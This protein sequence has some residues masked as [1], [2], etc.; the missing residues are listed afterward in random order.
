MRNL[1]ISFSCLILI[2]LYIPSEL[3]GKKDFLSIP[4]SK[5]TQECIDCHEVENPGLVAD[6]FASRHSKTTPK[7]A[8]Q[9]TSLEK[10]VSS[11]NIPE[12]LSSNAVGCYECHSL[13]SF[14]HKDNFEHYGFKINVIVSPKDCS[15]C[16]STEEKE[17]SNSKKANALDILQKNPLYHTLVET[18][19]S[20]KETDGFN[21]VSLKP[22]E[23]T[24][25]KTCYACHGTNVEVRRLKKVITES[26]EITVPDLT[27]WPNQGV[28]RINPDGS[29]GACTACHPRHNFSIE[30]A[31]K[32]YTCAQCHLAPD[33]P[34]WEIYKES[35]HGNIFLSKH[36]AT[37]WDQVP[38]TVGK[39]FQTPT[40][41]TCHNSLITNPGGDVIEK[42]THDFGSRLWV[43][44]FGLIYS[45]PQPKD[46]KTYLIKNADGLPLPTTFT[47][48]PASEYLLDNNEQRQ[49][50]ISMKKICKSCHTTDWINGHFIHLDSTIIETEKMVLAS[51]QLIQTAWEKGIADPTNPFDEAIEQKWVEQWLF[52]ANSVRYAAAMGGPDYAAFKNGWWDLTKN[53]QSMK[54][55][56]DIYSTKKTNND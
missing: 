42:R 11:N 45:H 21:I 10:R 3:I 1:I 19:T 37:N 17:Y 25:G 30:I 6:W 54:S 44:I 16:H 12:N 38:W 24:K 8:T 36:E 9:K 39:D 2:V 34:A 26:D 13:N 14:A 53:L 29:M 22:S 5:E 31:R 50:E 15:T 23:S 7:D 55:L 35:K 46:G 40:C 47:G 51:T 28:G 32:P 4:L 27:N 48:I 20:V 41:A 52:Y 49:R 33:V 56:I 43:R 18:I